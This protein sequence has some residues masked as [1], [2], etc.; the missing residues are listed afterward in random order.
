MLSRGLV[1]SRAKAQALV[2]AGE[3]TV[4]GQPVLKAGTPV[5]EDAEILIAQP[6]PYVSRGGLKLE[7]ALDQFKIDATGNIAADI[8]SS[9]GGF[10][11]C[12]LQRGAT[13]VYAIDVGTN[14]LAYRLRQDKR[15]VVMEGTNARYSLELPEAVDLVTIDLSFI[16]V[17]KVIPSV[18]QWLKPDGK[19]II[20]IKPQFEA[21]RQEIG[22]G[23]IIREPL[24]HARVLGRFITWATQNN[25]RLQ[26]LVASPILRASGNR[27]FLVLLGR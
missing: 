11:D 17:E 14:Q 26:G 25:F 1:A 16:S 24:I 10:T 20:L 21:L 19:I 9:T 12:L 8:G 7:H 13:R 18:T 2:M 15:V 22:K 4:N 5:S 23:G 27:E 3:V 6:P